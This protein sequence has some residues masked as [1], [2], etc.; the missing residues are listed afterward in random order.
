[1]EYHLLPDS[2]L[3]GSFQEFIAMHID[4]LIELLKLEIYSRFIF[5]NL[6]LFFVLR[7]H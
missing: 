6:F 7:P 5:V 2:K 1:M 3:L 4:C